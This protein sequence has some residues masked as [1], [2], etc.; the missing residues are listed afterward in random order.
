MHLRYFVPMK[1]NN[2]HPDVLHPV[3]VMVI[4]VIS[5]LLLL[6]TSGLR[7]EGGVLGYATSISAGELHTLSNQQ[8]SSNGLKGFT[9]NS[10]LSQAASAKAQHMFS[11]NYWA[12]VAPDGTSPWSFI[13]AQGYAYSTAGENLAKDF[14]VSSGVV[15]GWMGS[16]GHRANVLSTTFSEVGYAAVNGTLLGQQTTLVVAMYASPKA[17][18]A[19][20]PTPAAPKPASTAAPEATVAPPVS[21]PPASPTVPAA[22]P[23]PAPEKPA[24][25]PASE[26][27][28]APYTSESPT[29]GTVLNEQSLGLSAPVRLYRSL[30]WQQRIVIAFFAYL[31][32]INIL[33]HTLVW[34]AQKRGYKHIWLRHH[35]LLQAG[36]LIVG[37]IIVFSSSVGVV[38]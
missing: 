6:P 28:T 22:P 32:L 10:K 1:A 19:P 38:L 35:P 37:I 34:R 20:K 9:L 27:I 15:N 5:F 8:R 26:P 25:D 33:K 12:H 13:S 21:T 2:Y 31:A 29:D 17:A 36:L 7:P 30:A 23:T 4:I 24:E 18:A 16:S 3:I 14:S 11:Q